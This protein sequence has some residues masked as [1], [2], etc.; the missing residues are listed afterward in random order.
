MRRRSG[1][2][3]RGEEGL[4]RAG[5]VGW[6]PLEAVRGQPGGTGAKRVLFRSR[7]GDVEH[8]GRHVLRI[9]TGKLAQL[10]RKGGEH[11][12]AAGAEVEE[13]ALTLRLA[14]R[15]QDAGRRS[16]RVRGQRVPLQERD[17]DPLPREEVRRGAADHP[18]ADHD[19]I[20]SVHTSGGQITAEAQMRVGVCV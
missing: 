14:D 8:P 13:R 2:R 20:R 4:L 17:G 6:Q 12:Q 11:L 18:A 5:R 15:R 1:S 7:F 10:I 16:G 19:H 9:N 3:P